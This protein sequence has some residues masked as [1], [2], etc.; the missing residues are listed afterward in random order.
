[1]EGK[2]EIEKRRKRRE[3]EEGDVMEGKRERTAIGFDQSD[4]R[5]VVN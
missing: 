3:K 1:M 5:L 2:R 4:H